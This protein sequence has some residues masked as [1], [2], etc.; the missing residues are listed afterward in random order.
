MVRQV[1]KNNGSAVETEP[2]GETSAIGDEKRLNINGL[3][4]AALEREREVGAY[5]AEAAD[6]G[7]SPGVKTEKQSWRRKSRSGGEDSVENRAMLW[8]IA[9][10]ALEN[11]GVVLGSYTPV[12]VAVFPCYAVRR[13]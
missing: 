3:A 1:W 10:D 5:R 7:R 2:H 4:R 13:L 12:F 8:R 6:R 9:A 11:R